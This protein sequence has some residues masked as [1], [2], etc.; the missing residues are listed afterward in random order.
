MSNF[1]DINNIKR[2]LFN[3]TQGSTEEA[4]LYQQWNAV[5]LKQLQSAND[6][7]QL[8]RAIC[9]SPPKGEAHDLAQ[10]LLKENIPDDTDP[11]GGYF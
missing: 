11:D 3:S 6:L 8:T 10:K 1:D 2:Q 5:S 7:S 9:F 4:A